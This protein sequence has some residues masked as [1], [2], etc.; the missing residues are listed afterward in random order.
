M[1]NSSTYS[2]RVDAYELDDST[3][4]MSTTAHHP[5]PESPM[6]A[7]PE[8]QLRAEDQ[9]NHSKSKPEASRRGGYAVRSI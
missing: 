2:T 9:A 8:D 5:R 6:E 1:V 4:Q 7:L 3:E